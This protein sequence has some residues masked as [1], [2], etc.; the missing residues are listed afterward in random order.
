MPTT[1]PALTATMM[2]LKV[3]LGPT[4]VL[5]GV[6]G[7]C[8]FSPTGPDAPVLIETRG[9]EMVIRDQTVVVPFTVTNT[10]SG[11]NYY[12]AACGDQPRVVADRHEGA[13]WVQHSGGFCLTVVPMFPILL[14]PGQEA[15]YVTGVRVL[16]PGIYRLR[17]GLS[18]D[19]GQT[20]EWLT[21]SN[22]FVAR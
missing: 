5:I 20:P 3:M 4:L 2:A 11:V 9:S 7:A 18:T 22:S 19:P 17:L 15:R 16:E 1:T 6:A 13:G 14:K 12:M 21:T 8:S 10:T